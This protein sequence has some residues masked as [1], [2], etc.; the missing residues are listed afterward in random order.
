MISESQSNLE[1]GSDLSLD[2]EPELQDSFPI[3]AIG[4]S[5]GGLE[6]FTELLANLPNDTGMGFVLIQ[7]LAPE[8]DSQLSEILRRTTEM[9]VNQA[10]EGMRIVP[11]SVYVIPPNTLMTLEQGILRLEPRRKVRG[12]YMVIDGFFSS[13]AAD[14]GENAIAVL[15]S[16]S[17]EDGTVGLGVIKSVGGVTFA[18]E[19]TSAEYP[20]MPMIAIASGYVDMV[21]AP[22]EIAAE[23]VII[24]Q[25]ANESRAVIDAEVTRD[26]IDIPSTGIFMNSGET[27]AHI[28]SLLLNRMG[29]DFSNYKQGTIRR[30]IARRMGLLNLKDLEAYREFLQTHPDEVEKLYH[31]ILINVTSFFREPES[32]K[33]LQE[34]VFP[35][36]CEYKSFD[37]P[38]R[39]WVAGCSTGEEV[40]SIAISLLEFFGNRPAK[41]PIQIFATDISE[42]AIN[43]ARLGIYNHQSLVD[44]SPERLRQFFTQV[45]D[46]YQIGKSVRELCVFARQNLTS[47]PPF[48]RLDLISC[49]NML[50]Y[51]EPVL[52]KKVMP[53]FHYALNPNGFLMLGSS[54]GIGSASDLFAIANKKNRIYNRKPTAPQMN[55][56][57]VKSTYVKQPEIP[58][59]RILPEPES[60]LEQIADQIVLN[61]YAP[62]GVIVN[63]DLDILQFRGQTSLYLEAAAGKASLNL[64]KM[65][66]PELMLEL[67]SLLYDA[68][69]QNIPITKDNIPMS[70]LLVKINVI[71]LQSDNETHF[72]VLFESR[73]EPILSANPVNAPVSKSRKERQNEVNIEIARLTH[74]LFKTKEYLRSIIESQEATNQDLKVASEEYLSSNEE[75]QSANEE[76]ETAK[77]EIQATNEE[78]STVNEEMRDRNTQLNFVNNDLQNLLKSVNIPILMLSGDLRIRRFTPMAEQ[79][80]NLIASDVG[81][82]FS[83][84]QTNIGVP[85]LMGLISQVLDTL[86]PFEQDVQS[87]TGHWDILRIRPYRTTDNVIDG[88]VISLF[89]IDLLKNSAIEL[90]FSRNYANAIIETLRQPLVVLNAQMQVVTANHAFY[91]VFQIGPALTEQRSFFDLGQ[92]EWNIPKLQSLLN[93]ILTIGI[94][95]QDYEITQNFAKLG[96]R[97]MLLNICQIQQADQGK[98][99]LL[100]IEDITERKLQKQQLIAQNQALLEAI[101]A[102]D[103]AN[104][105]K[106][107]FLGNVSHELRTPLNSIMGF[108]QLLQDHPNLDQESLEFINIIYRSGEHLFALIK[109]L[110]DISR[111]EAD[112][113]ELEPRLLCLASFLQAT[114]SMVYIK[115]DQKNL[116]FTTDFASDLPET[117]Y[118][119]EKRLKQ[120]ILNLL[121]NAIKFTSAGQITFSVRKITNAPKIQFAIADTGTGIAAPELAKIFLPFEQVGEVAVKTEGT[122]LGLAISQD[123][124][125]RMGGE[126]TVVSQIG[127]GSIFSF[128][129]DLSTPPTMGLSPLSIPES[130]PNPQSL[131]SGAIASSTPPQTTNLLEAENSLT[132]SLPPAGEED[133]LTPSPSPAG[134]EDL[135]TPSPSPAGEED[136]LTPSP[137]PAGEGDKRILSILVAEDVTYNQMLIKLFLQKLGYQPDIVSNGLEV[138]AKLREKRYDIILM[139]IQMPQMDGMEATRRIVAGYAE[140]DRPYII[141]VSANSS[142][143]DQAQYLALGMNDAIA[144]PYVLD[145]LQEALSR[146]NP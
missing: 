127:V 48:S 19:L 107:K 134:E 57:F 104:Q 101:A 115:A 58:V 89:D 63:V 110:L 44:I 1:A 9:P 50:I 97:T 121:S 18:Q 86:I 71:P 96:T 59:K 106:S 132:P 51:L 117:I 75:L 5:A 136:P 138:L 49:R 111:I 83:D 29:V 94:S 40:Y 2:L 126:I 131:I 66:R 16:G 34:L 22:E 39:I 23:L 128:E 139:D 85:D 38:I 12:K 95:V 146:F 103:A 52:Q 69:K 56:N 144:K 61:Q 116:T 114:V 120:V 125:N 11:N 105:A 68:K 80:F 28:F 130:P 123:I 140:S 98:M 42:I 35:A 30:R 113:M 92:G 137:S 41:H 46:G 74:E 72:L 37:A 21:L 17:N 6:A 145:E 90:S 15:L 82:P 64:L 142:G 102:S 13:L 45:Q 108:S 77:E 87:R 81:R 62:V 133:P 27:L 26:A 36:I 70:S 124:I 4:A 8:H 43:K 129:L 54:E 79:A 112:K 60:N 10:Q 135:L 65:A 118:A 25:K 24:S 109:D 47:D 143:E 55:F 119:D 84:I 99:I 76:L 3:A 141:A 7:H 32:F 100:A 67:R 78:L 31:D 33:V 91:T 53:I 14:R 93:Q 122:G 73:T 88:V 20:T